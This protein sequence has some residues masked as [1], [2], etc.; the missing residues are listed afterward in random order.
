MFNLMML[1]NNKNEDTF[2]LLGLFIRNNLSLTTFPSSIAS[3][4]LKL[5]FLQ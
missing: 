1:S 4:F 2:N 3:S 5:K